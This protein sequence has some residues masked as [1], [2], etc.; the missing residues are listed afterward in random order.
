MVTT[1]KWRHALTG[2]V[3]VVLLAAAITG[4]GQD[5]PGTGNDTSSPDHNPRVT[6]AAA[7]FAED[8]PLPADCRPTDNPPPTEYGFVAAITQ[9]SVEGGVMELDGLQGRMCGIIRLAAG[10]HPECPVEG[11]L[12]IPSDGVIFPDDL[13]TTLNVVPGMQPEVPTA[14]TAHPIEHAIDCNR[15]S[16]DGLTLDLSIVVDGKAG[17]FGLECAVPFSG[18]A[19]TRITGELFSGDYTGEFTLSG[20]EFHAG[21]VG[22]NDKYCPGE[23]PDHVNKIAQLPGDDYRAELS[24]D[25]A[26]YQ[27]PVS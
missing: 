11:K 6:R 3:A 25:V 20:D 13:T 18:I 16:Q 27:N 9:G 1:P 4:A 23:L 17:A 2:L 21:S 24:G 10:T 15:S 22:N 7:E 8:I 5:R 14:V 26:I 19:R 12:I